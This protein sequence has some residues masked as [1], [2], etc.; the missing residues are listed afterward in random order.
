[1]LMRSPFRA[2]CPAFRTQNPRGKFVAAGH[3][4]FVV[5][6]AR[7]GANSSRQGLA[8]CIGLM[9]ASVGLEPMGADHPLHLWLSSLTR[10]GST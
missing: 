2:N 4:R 7:A 6:I 1:M 8:A 5:V 9:L 10:P 3:L